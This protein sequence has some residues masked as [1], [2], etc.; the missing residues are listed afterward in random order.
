MELH[1]FDV[2]DRSAGS[3]SAGDTITS[4]YVGVRGVLEYSSKAT[5]SEECSASYDEYDRAACFVEGR[6]AD[7]FAIGYE[8]IGYGSKALKLDVVEGSGMLLERTD[9][10][11]TG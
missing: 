8:E 9:D 3:I 7:D 1:E 11:A 5:R 2:R 6:D 4:G 10:F